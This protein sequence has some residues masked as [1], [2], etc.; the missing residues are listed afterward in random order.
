MTIPISDRERVT[1]AMHARTIRWLPYVRIPITCIVISLLLFPL[2]L[3]IA[4]S[5]LD[6]QDGRL[7]SGTLHM[8]DYKH[9][10][11]ESRKFAVGFLNSCTYSLWITI[12]Q[13]VLAIPAAVSLAVF[14]FRGRSI[15]V[16]LYIVLML[17]PYQVTMVPSFIAIRSLH[18][19]DSPLAVVIPQLFMP[20]SVIML[21]MCL[22]QIEQEIF[23]AG[24]M[25]GANTFRLML[26][27]IIPLIAQ[28]IGAVALLVFIDSWNMLEQPLLFIQSIA[29]MP[30]SILIRQ[31]IE[32][33]ASEVFVPA[34]LFLIPIAILYMLF[35]NAIVEGMQLGFRSSREREASTIT[36]T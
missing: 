6:V 1:A 3:L 12:G 15:V 18:L 31:S 16:V 17:M 5:I 25:D 26:H 8:A 7:L 4:Y 22:I 9:M 14:K 19:M 33:N 24:R 28:G 20:F 10:M 21:Y 32:G 27:I 30:L 13:L 36:I 35:R 29:Y 23:E 11:L 34:V 2:A